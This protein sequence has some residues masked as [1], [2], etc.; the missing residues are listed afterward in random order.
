[1]LARMS[2]GLTVLALALAFAIGAAG[3][4]SANPEIRHEQPTRPPVTTHR[5]PNLGAVDNN[6]GLIRDNA[7]RSN[8]ALQDAGG[9]DAEAKLAELKDRGRELEMQIIGMEDELRTLMRAF[10]NSEAGDDAIDRIDRE[11]DARDQ[12]KDEVTEA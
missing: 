10:L 6:L 9:D 5:R 2:A 11:T 12:Q 4:A 1:M 8:P 7:R 3:T